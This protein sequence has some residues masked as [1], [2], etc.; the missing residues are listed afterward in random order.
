MSDWSKE[1]PT[2]FVELHQSIECVWKVESK[3]CSDRVKEQAYDVLVTKDAN[4]DA[5]VK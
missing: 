5:V 2:E 1:F 3:D 4:R